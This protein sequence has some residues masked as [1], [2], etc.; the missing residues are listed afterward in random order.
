MLS[1]RS[2]KLI[3]EH[4]YKV[5]EGS[6]TYGLTVLVADTILDD[7]QAQKTVDILNYVLRSLAGEAA[8]LI[9][10]QR[11]DSSTFI[12]VSWDSTKSRSDDI[13]LRIQEIQDSLSLY[14]CTGTPIRT[15]NRAGAGTKGTRLI[16]A[17]LPNVEGICLLVKKYPV[18]TMVFREFHVKFHILD[19]E[20]KIVITKQ[21]KIELEVQDDLLFRLHV[22]PLEVQ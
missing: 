11:K 1:I 7:E 8:D 13:G 16:E 5:Y 15:T 18:P 10:I 4:G 22:L 6:E 14:F 9:A 19:S 17:V 3:Q 12:Q 20:G 2:R 21:H